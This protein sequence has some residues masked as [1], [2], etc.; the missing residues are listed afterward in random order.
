V[1]N[2]VTSGKG[3]V[4]LAYSVS[5]QP[6]EC[7]SSVLG[8]IYFRPLKV[9]ASPLPHSGDGRRPRQTIFLEFAAAR[10]C[11][12]PIERLQR[13]ARQ[14]IM[15]RDADVRGPRPSPQHRAATE[16][17]PQRDHL[18]GQQLPPAPM[19]QRIR[20]TGKPL[21]RRTQQLRLS[22][23]VIGTSGV[24]ECHAC[25]TLHKGGIQVTARAQ[26]PGKG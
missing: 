7:V 18:A 21:S 22:Q 24:D 6:S 14:A 19:P 26:K 17:R 8:A 25:A 3:E 11:D 23:P 9:P 20:Q 4:L 1:L 16:M 5:K 13:W 12:H 15:A 10:S 2:S